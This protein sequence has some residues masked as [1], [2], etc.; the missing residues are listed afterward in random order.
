MK[1]IK[2]EDWLSLDNEKWREYRF[3]NG[4][5]VR[6]ESPLKIIVSKNGHR[7]IA[8]SGDGVP[9]SHYIPTGWIHL[10]WEGKEKPA[11]RW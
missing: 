4:E 1:K 10:Y 5:Y 3:P 6:I 9:E 8:K 7:I 11:Y 2:E